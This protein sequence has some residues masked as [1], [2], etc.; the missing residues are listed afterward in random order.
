MDNWNGNV[1]QMQ[2]D[3]NR[4]KTSTSNYERFLRSLSLGL[5]G[6]QTFYGTKG[7]VEGE[8]ESSED[9]PFK[10][11]KKVRD[12]TFDYGVDSFQSGL[13]YWANLVREG[14]LD[15]VRI[16]VHIVVE[17]TDDQ[18]FKTRKGEVFQYT[19]HIT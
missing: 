11:L 10:F 9:D 2:R 19:Y 5:E 7:F 4:M 1:N 6:L 16:P 18:G 15:T 14:S 3:L 13:R 8:F 12:N 17:V